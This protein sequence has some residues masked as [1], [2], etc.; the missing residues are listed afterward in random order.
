MDERGTHHADVEKLVAG[1]PRVEP[2]GEEP[3]G[4]P[5]NVEESSENVDA[6]H[7][8]EPEEAL[9]DVLLLE[10]LAECHL[11]P[12]DEP[13][14]PEEKEGGEAEGT[15]GVSPELF[16]ERDDHTAR[17]EEHND[18]DVCVLGHRVAVEPVV[19]ARDAGTG[20]EYGDA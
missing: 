5:R 12:G 14:Q 18:G 19:V 11:D 15:I 16:P 17:A 8:H 9:I 1:G 13:I 10:P 4:K 2:A 7:D 20:D 6:G 3:L